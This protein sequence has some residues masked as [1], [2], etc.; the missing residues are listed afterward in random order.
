MRHTYRSRW[1]ARE[2]L[3]RLPEATPRADVLDGTAAA[4][5]SNVRKD[6]LRRWMPESVAVV[7]T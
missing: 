5:R 4:A 6:R 1:H 7:P 2:A 3:E